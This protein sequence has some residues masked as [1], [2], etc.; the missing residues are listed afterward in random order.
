MEEDLEAT[1]A[2]AMPTA[3]KMALYTA[4][5]QHYEIRKYTIEG[6]D[7]LCNT[8]S[9][10]K[11]FDDHRNAGDDDQ[12]HLS[13]LEDTTK[14]Y[15]VLEMQLSQYKKQLEKMEGLIEQGKFVRAIATALLWYLTVC[16][17]AGARGH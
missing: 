15:A 8:A 6:V 9:L 1:I 17:I 4:K 14:Q 3:L 16:L 7:S 5:K 11:D 2:R 13:S 12:Q 10:L